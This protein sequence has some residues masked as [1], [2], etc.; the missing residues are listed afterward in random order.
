VDNIR[1]HLES[2]WD[3]PFLKKTVV[4]FSMQFLRVGDWARA[5]TGALY[6]ELSQVVST[7]HALGSVGLE[8]CIDGRPKTVDFRLQD[9]ERVFRVGDTVRV[10]AGPYLGLEGYILQMCE[11]VFRICQAVSKEEVDNFRGLECS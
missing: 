10:V 9:V 11:D 6:S 3:K 8:F 7:D 5:N 2:G 4:A 1:L